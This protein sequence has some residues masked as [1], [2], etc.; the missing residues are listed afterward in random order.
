VFL[1]LG[2]WFGIM[3]SLMFSGYNH[4]GVS[5][6][7][8]VSFWF[9]CFVSFGRALDVSCVFCGVWVAV[10]G[11]SWDLREFWVFLAV[12]VWFLV[13]FSFLGVSCCV[14]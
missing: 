6:R 12:F 1:F 11:V 7:N 14:W 5:W 10:A 2:F 4:F 3:C 8:L 13:G 9:W